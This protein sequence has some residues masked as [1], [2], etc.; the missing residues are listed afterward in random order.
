MGS[1]ANPT[2]VSLLTIRSIGFGGHGAVKNKAVSNSDQTL[3][4]PD[5]IL[6]NCGEGTGGTS[7]DSESRARKSEFGDSQRLEMP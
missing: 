5:M 7:L 4:A 2:I 1:Q 6:L 3:E